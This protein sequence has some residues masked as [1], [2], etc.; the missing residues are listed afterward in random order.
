MGAT[1]PLR[2]VATHRNGLPIWEASRATRATKVLWESWVQY[3]LLRN[4]LPIWEASRA[5]RA[6]K[7]LWESWVQYTLLRNE[8]PIWEASRAT[9][10]GFQL[11]I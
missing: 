8:L 2:K 3:T 5:T 9:R 10:A 7:V 11:P 4:E 6:T 1:C